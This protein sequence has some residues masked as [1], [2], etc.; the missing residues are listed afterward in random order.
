MAVIKNKKTEQNREFW[1]HVEQISEQVDRWRPRD[2]RTGEI[3]KSS[4]RQ[5]CRDTE[6]GESRKRRG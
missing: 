6:L 1:R 2:V 5:H 4:E 3:N